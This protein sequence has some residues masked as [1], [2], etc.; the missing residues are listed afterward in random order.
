MAIARS[1]TFMSGES[2]ALLL[3]ESVAFGIGVELLI[4]RSGD[5]L[6]I[7]PARMTTTTMQERLAA[8]PA[9]SE[10][11]LRE[12]GPLTDRELR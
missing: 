5:V 4:V 11:E 9:P 6:T 2:E 12:T 10:I 3:P 8:L 1:R 7:Y